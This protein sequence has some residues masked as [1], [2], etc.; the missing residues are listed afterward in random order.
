MTHLYYCRHGLSVMNQQGLLCGSTDSPLSDEGSRQAMLAG[1]EAKRQGLTFDAIITSPMARAHETAQLLARE[2][3]YP[4]D[5]IIATP[6]L[7]ERD[8]GALEGTIW[9]PQMD[10]HAEPSVEPYEHIMERA[11]QAKNLLDALDGSVLLVG[12]GA[13]IRAVRSLYLPD[14]PYADATEAMPNAVITRIL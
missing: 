3:G 10:L 2:L 9:H 11:R 6:L 13:I 4:Q 12:H 8:F 14:M 7:V 5:K 1:Q